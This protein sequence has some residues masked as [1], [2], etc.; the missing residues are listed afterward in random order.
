MGRGDAART[1]R[2][3]PAAAGRSYAADPAGSAC[4][5]RSIG[6][7]TKAL[8]STGLSIR[9]GVGE[10]V[11]ASRH[12]EPLTAAAG[13]GTPQW[14]V[15]GRPGQTGQTGQTSRGRAVADRE[16]ESRTAGASGAGRIPTKL[17]DRSLPIGIALPVL[18]QVEGEADGRSPRGWLP[19]L[20]PLKPASARR[21]LRMLSARMLL[22][23]LPVHRNKHRC[24]R[25][26]PWR[27]PSFRPV[28]G[29]RIAQP[30]SRRAPA[31]RR[32]NRPAGNRQ[33]HAVPSTSIA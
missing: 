9:E 29:N 1:L 11:V 24:T 3:L 31:G 15:I 33:D 8:D 22:A 27:C 23:E 18:Q 5:A 12:R 21:R 13:S 14:A 20:Y 16:N 6:R 10:G 30:N 17:L 19:A 4:P 32:N 26:P 2:R 25:I 7:L 28:P